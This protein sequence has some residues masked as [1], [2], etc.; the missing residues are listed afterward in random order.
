MKRH[1]SPIRAIRLHCLWCCLNQPTEVRLCGA[2]NCASYPFRIGKRV[3]GLKPLDIIKSHCTECSGDET[4][5]SCKL[6][7]CAL[8]PFRDG[9]NPNRI[10]IG[11]YFPNQAGLR[12]NSRTHALILQGTSA[13]TGLCLCEKPCAICSCSERRSK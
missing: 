5:K 11:N 10:G 9:R 3:E 2:V 12:R 13:G 8:H 4:A 6:A 7:S 1:P